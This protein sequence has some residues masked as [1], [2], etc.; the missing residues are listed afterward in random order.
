MYTSIQRGGCQIIYQ[1]NNYKNILYNIKRISSTYQYNTWFRIIIPAQ[2][3]NPNSGSDT[4][5]VRRIKQELYAFI[6]RI[7]R[8][9]GIRAPFL[10]EIESSISV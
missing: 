6:L 3:W 2:G 4:Y 1:P 5:Y 9:G 7:H 8:I 10:V